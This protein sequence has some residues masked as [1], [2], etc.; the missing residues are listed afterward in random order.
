M[1]FARHLQEHSIHNPFPGIVRLEQKIGRDIITRIGSNESQP[2]PSPA[3]TTFL[4]ETAVTMAS[5]YPDPYAHDIR[6]LA[7]AINLVDE[8][9]VIV[10]SGADS[11]ILLSLRLCC[12]VGDTVI[13]SAGSYPTFRYFAEGCGQRVV[14]VSL[15]SG[16]DGALQADLGALAFNAHQYKASLVYLANPDNP[17]GHYHSQTEIER[18]RQSLPADCVLLLD[19]AYL[20]FAEPRHAA[21]PVMDNTLRLRTLSKAYALAGLRVGYAIAPAE[22]IAKADEIRPQFAVS[23][24]AQQAA[25]LALQA[26]EAA[27]SLLSTTI[28]LREKLRDALLARRLRVLDSHTNFVSIPYPDSQAAEQVQRRLFAMGVAVHRPAHPATSHLIRITA[29]PAALDEAILDMLIL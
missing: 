25:I 12:N 13:T 14:E 16:T 27:E 11:L 5:L 2:L 3:L 18:F 23:S 10:D 28:S 21:S 22:A 15:Q 20:E 24:L 19:E 6:R 7:A 8:S 1:R 9:E 17:T 4:G 29:H 26:R